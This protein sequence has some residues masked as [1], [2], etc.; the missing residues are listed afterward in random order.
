M[1]AS[2]LA[3]V[4]TEPTEPEVAVGFEPVHSGQHDDAGAD[5]AAGGRRSGPR[6]WSS[7]RRR[8]TSC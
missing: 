7:A 3:A 6:R 5:G 1:S 4:A 2:K 8:C